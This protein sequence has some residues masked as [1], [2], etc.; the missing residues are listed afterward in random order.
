MPPWCTSKGRITPEGYIALRCTCGTS[1]R[2]SKSETLRYVLYFA[3]EA[4]RERTVA[5]VR[6]V[7]GPGS[8]SFPV[9][10]RRS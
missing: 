8:R 7:S 3:P 6:Q 9:M 1:H 10:L 4:V 2:V 5:C